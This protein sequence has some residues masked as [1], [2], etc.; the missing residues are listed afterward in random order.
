MSSQ[1]VQVLGYQTPG[2]VV[3]DGLSVTLQASP[4]V[5]E[6][7]L[8]TVALGAC[9]IGGL[10]GFSLAVHYLRGPLRDQEISLGVTSALL[11][12]GCVAAMTRSFIT[13]LRRLQFGHLP[14][15]IEVHG[16]KLYV[17]CPI[18][19]GLKVRHF[20][21]EDLRHA[22]ITFRGVTIALRA[23]YVLTLDGFDGVW[24][25]IRF[26]PHDADQCERIRVQ[27]GNIL[28]AAQEVNSG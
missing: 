1:P 4:V 8:L 21:L 3:D 26:A 16:Q 24:A 6:T 5:W 18:M 20:R 27:M 2:V 23:A 25:Q 14:S 15:S 22:T 11:F 10:L 12:A 19:W 9:A 17:Q 7:V 28:R 13:I